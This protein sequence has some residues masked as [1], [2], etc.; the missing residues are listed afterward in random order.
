MLNALISVDVFMTNLVKHIIQS[1]WS[2]NENFLWLWM[3]VTQAVLCSS[4]HMLHPAQLCL[5]TLFPY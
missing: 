5:Q 2:R 1:S 3:H 4:I